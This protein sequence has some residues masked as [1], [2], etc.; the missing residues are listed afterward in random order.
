MFFIY[1]FFPVIYRF[2]FLSSE[3]IRTK[4][5]IKKNM[6]IIHIQSKLAGKGVADKPI[7]SK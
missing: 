4:D 7:T 1:I 3:I 2:L 6:P 5:K